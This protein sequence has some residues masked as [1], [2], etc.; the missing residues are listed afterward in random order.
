MKGGISASFNTRKQPTK[1]K[2]LDIY[3]EKPLLTIKTI[4]YILFV[5]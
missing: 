3:T 5:Y 4:Y 1:T 2:F